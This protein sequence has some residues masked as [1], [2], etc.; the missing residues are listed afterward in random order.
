MN[1][2]FAMLPAVGS[3]FPKSANRPADLREGA[4]KLKIARLS[5]SDGK[6]P[7]V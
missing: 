4:A 6:G 3:G 1:P 2:I 5:N 7:I